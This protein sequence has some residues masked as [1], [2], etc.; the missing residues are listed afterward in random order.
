M[1]IDKVPWLLQFECGTTLSK[2]KAQKFNKTE[3]LLVFDRQG[4][5]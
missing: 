3:Q 1:I 2:K 5:V 4:I